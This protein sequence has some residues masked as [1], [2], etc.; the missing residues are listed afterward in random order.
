MKH[1]IIVE[2]IQARMAELNTNAS[3]V[4]LKAGLGKTA[5]RDIV[6]GKS[7]KPTTDTMARIAR[8]LDCTLS[9]LVGDVDD[10]QQMRAASG[11][12]DLQ[13]TSISHIVEA[14]VFK[15][16]THPASS[17]LV[18]VLEHPG[19]PEHSLRAYLMGD[20]SMIEYGIRKGDILTVAAPFAEKRVPLTEG[21]L[22]ICA[23]S[24]A[25]PMVTEVSARVVKIADGVVHLLTHYADGKIDAIRLVRQPEKFP[26][27]LYISEGDT[28]ITIDGI[29]V[30]LMRDFG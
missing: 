28:G 23:Q 26:E 17:T 12:L 10:P 18:P 2:R 11:P 3:T 13:M 16:D 29:I 5:V 7:K 8:A 24:L 21:R 15:R 6:A 30:R 1:H 9:Y 4:S 19:Y 14:G 27:N 25:P 20:D 22:V